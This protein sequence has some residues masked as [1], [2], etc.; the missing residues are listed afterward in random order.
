M[1]ANPVRR[2]KILFPIVLLA[3][4]V[5]GY[6]RYVAIE[7]GV[8]NPYGIVIDYRVLFALSAISILPLAL[9]YKRT[10]NILFLLVKLVF[11]LFIITLTNDDIVITVVVS[12]AFLF[13]TGFYLRLPYNLVLAVFSGAAVLLFQR[14]I[15]F[16]KGVTPTIRPDELTMLGFLFLIIVLLDYIIALV[17]RSLETQDGKIENQKDTI[18]RLIETNVGAQRF[19][20]TKKGEYEDAERLRITRDIHDTIGYVMTNNIMLLRACTYYVPKRLTKAQSFLK[21]ALENA[22]KG[23]DETRGILKKLHDINTGTS[24]AE[25]IIKIITLFRESTG[26]NVKH[27]FGNTMG[28]WDKDINAAFY[29]IIQEGLVNSVKHGKATEISIGFWQTRE[30]ITLTISDNGTVKQEEEAKR[31]I[32]LRGM[33]ERLSPLRGSLDARSYPH[34]FSLHI[35]VPLIPVD[36]GVAREDD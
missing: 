34:G 27:S 7:A 14:S 10:A 8:I 18:I 31:G 23:L 5:F 3:G 12:S 15:W 28:T 29:R 33:E 1:K 9:F 21:N 6:F 30:E 16:D 22:E 24:G 4:D 20:L 32:G 13:A 26:I 2:C 11:M 25:E 35:T 36:S 19:A 17:I